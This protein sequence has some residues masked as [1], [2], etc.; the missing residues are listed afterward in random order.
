MAGVRVNDADNVR[1]GGMD[2]AV[3]YECRLVDDVVDVVHELAGRVHLD[4][5][6][7]R[8]LLVGEAERI[9]QVMMRRARHR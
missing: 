9:Q 4:Q 5:I 6:R 3:N 2:R 8:N 1:P 7:S